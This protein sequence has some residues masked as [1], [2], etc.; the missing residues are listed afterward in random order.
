MAL[1]LRR[2]SD[3]QRVAI[4]F[5][6]GEI[7]YTTDTKKLY[8]G[9]G[10]TAGGISAT[11]YPDSSPSVLDKNLSL[12]GFD[13]TGTGDININGDI[14]VVS[15]N[16]NNNKI[17]SEYK[18]VLGQSVLKISNTA[19]NERAY[20]SLDS[21]YQEPN[22]DLVRYA[23]TDISEVPLTYGLLKFGRN[24]VNGLKYTSSIL[25]SRDQLIFSVSKDSQFNENVSLT[26]GDGGKLGIKTFSPVATLDVRGTANIS[27]YLIIGKY[28]NE[29]RPAGENGMLIY[30]TSVNKF[31]A[32]QNDIWINIDNGSAA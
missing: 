23:T 19:Q 32:F 14:S 15:T 4:T 24:D 12:N 26:W 5:A 13:I 6:E 16:I 10:V 25:A 18:S 29:T 28:S 31:Q 8:V 11:E 27:E 17:S 3:A 20:I 30:N 9:D 7:V 22:L 21:T 1:Q 2:G